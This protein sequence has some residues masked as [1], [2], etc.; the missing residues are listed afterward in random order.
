MSNDADSDDESNDHI[1]DRK[2]NIS[3]PRK[4]IKEKGLRKEAEERG[5]KFDEPYDIWIGSF[6]AIT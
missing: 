5:G 6:L 1:Y 3:G 2:L 4:L